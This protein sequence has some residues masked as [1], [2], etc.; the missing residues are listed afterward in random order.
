MT[1]RRKLLSAFHYDVNVAGAWVMIYF[2]AF[3]Y[4]VQAAGA[5]EV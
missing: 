2:S 1:R 3:N 5:M 4:D